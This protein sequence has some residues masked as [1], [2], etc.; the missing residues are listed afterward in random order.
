MRVLIFL[1]LATIVLTAN[2]SFAKISSTSF[3]DIDEYK[4]KAASR[5]DEIV[6]GIL[7]VRRCNYS[8]PENSS[9][10]VSKRQTEALLARI[11]SEDVGQILSELY[12]ILPGVEGADKLSNAWAVKGTIAFDGKKVS[13]KFESVL[14]KRDA[15][16]DTMKA[17]YLNYDRVYDGDCDIIFQRMYRQ[18]TINLGL[19]PLKLF[20]LDNLRPIV[21]VQDDQ[22]AFLSNAP[23][24]HKNIKELKYRNDMLGKLRLYVDTEAGSIVSAEKGDGNSLTVNLALG[25]RSYDGIRFPVL[26]GSF[27]YSNDLLESFDFVAIDHA[28]FNVE[29]DPSYFQVSVPADINLVD[30]RKDPSGG[31]SGRLLQSEK[32]ILKFADTQAFWNFKKQPAKSYFISFLIIAF[33]F[34]L[35]IVGVRIMIRLRELKTKPPQ[36]T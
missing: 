26:S 21:T 1:C 22:S 18:V 8:K 6:T 11:N 27:V 9:I 2:S 10:R 16:I 34:F 33:G 36:A 4:K 25:S 14:P 35:L 29:I 5:K 7:N 28:K 32:D 20:D 19:S 23:G 31:H 24:T 12:K 15:T 3:A 30:F 17:F 13:N